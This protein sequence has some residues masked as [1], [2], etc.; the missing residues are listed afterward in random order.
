MSDDPAG[1]FVALNSGKLIALRR[2]LHAHPELG[3]AEHA[4]DGAVAELLTGA[5]LEPRLP[6]G[7]G[8]WCDI[9]D[10]TAR[11]DRRAASRPRRAAARRPQGR[12]LPL[13]GA[14]ASATP[15]A[16]TSTPRSCWAPGWRSRSSRA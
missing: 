16:T 11:P 9:G 3:R 13:A 14:R 4:H 10:E 6:A 7:T 1:S 5:G 12:A 2:E 8:L 15:A